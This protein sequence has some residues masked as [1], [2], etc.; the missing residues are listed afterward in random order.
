M[1]GFGMKIALVPMRM[2]GRLGLAGRGAGARSTPP[3]RG[4]RGGPLKAYWDTWPPAA[5]AD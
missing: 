5:A 4:G 1:G 2:D 3:K